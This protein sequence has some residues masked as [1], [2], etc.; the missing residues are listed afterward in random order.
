GLR[1]VLREELDLDLAALLHG[2]DGRLFH[3][4][5]SLGGVLGRSILAGGRRGLLRPGRPKRNERP[6]RSEQRDQRGGGEASLHACASLAFERRGRTRHYAPAPAGS[7]TPSRE[8]P[9]DTVPS[10]RP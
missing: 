1:S 2:D 10:H 9:G 4:F 3:L 6:E 5:P 7:A 8:A